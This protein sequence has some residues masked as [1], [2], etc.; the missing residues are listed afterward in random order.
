MQIYVE[1]ELISLLTQAQTAKGQIQS[2]LIFYKIQ[3]QNLPMY[4]KYFLSKYLVH[5][6]LQLLT[7]FSIAK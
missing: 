7:T 4:Q 1:N 5:Q 3:Y 6:G 2:I